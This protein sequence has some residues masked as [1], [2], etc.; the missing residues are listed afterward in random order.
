MSTPRVCPWCASCA[1]WSRLWRIG[2]WWKGGRA[3]WRTKRGRARPWRTWPPSCS[4]CTRR[5]SPRGWGQLAE[6][7]AKGGGARAVAMGFPGPEGLRR[8]LG[9]PARLCSCLRRSLQLRWAPPLHEHHAPSPMAPEES[10]LRGG[11]T[12]AG[13]SL[14]CP[15]ARLWLLSNEV[16]PCIGDK[17]VWS[18]SRACLVPN[19]PDPL[20]MICH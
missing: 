7:R 18:C 11:C 15:D 5:S 10:C 1:P 13:H 12:L 16:R 19:C 17:M 9:P 4:A 6:G 8:R 20:P 14:V 2:R 3:S